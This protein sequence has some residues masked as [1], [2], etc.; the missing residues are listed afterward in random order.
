MKKIIFFIILL[1]LVGCNNTS[2]HECAMYSVNGFEVPAILGESTSYKT[3]DEVTSYI[4]ALLFAK[5][6]LAS[7]KGGPLVTKIFDMIKDDYVESGTIMA[8]C[9]NLEVHYYIYVNADDKYILLDPEGQLATKKWFGNYDRDFIFDSYTELEEEIN[10]LTFDNELKKISKINTYMKFGDD[11]REIAYKSN[12]PL[13]KYDNYVVPLALGPQKISDE[14]MCELIKNE[15][16]DKVAETITTVADAINY[17]IKKDFSVDYG[18]SG[19]HYYKN[20]DYADA[21]NLHYNDEWVLYTAPGLELLSIKA[22][23]CSASCTLMKYLLENDYPEVGYVHITGH[24]M[25]YVR[26]DDGKYYLVQPSD[27]LKNR[28]SVPWED[29]YE[30]GEDFCADTLKELMEN[31]AEV[32][33]NNGCELNVIFTYCYDGTICCGTLA[34]PGPGEEYQ[35]H[36][37]PKGS[38]PMCWYG[39][40]EVGEFVPKHETSQN[41]IIG[42]PNLEYF[43]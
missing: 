6:N 36:Y 28:L 37:F 2:S 40:V 34:T 24:A 19:T 1:I 16:N 4:D 5:D 33:I 15:N 41:R 32:Y 7:Y 9:D 35:K 13:I 20:M 29:T 22:L 3:K 43:E 30:D 10:S 12:V 42:L 14:Q 18:N 26:A 27:Y 31:F 23:Q 39:N 17:M 8:Q 38:N 21:G 25:L 11:T